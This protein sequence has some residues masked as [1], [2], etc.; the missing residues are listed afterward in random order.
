MSSPHYSHLWP[1]FAR[2]ASPIFLTVLCSFPTF[3]QIAKPPRVD[4]TNPF[5]D[6]AIQGEVRTRDDQP[7]PQDTIV[8]LEAVDGRPFAEQRIGAD[9]KFQFVNPPK[10]A[11]RLSVIATRYKTVT[12]TIDTTYGMPQPLVIKLDPIGSTAPP[13]QATVTD[14]AAPKQARREYEKGWQAFSLGKLKE[15]QRHLEKA[16]AE[17]PCFARA[18]TALGIVF[19]RVQQFEAADSA[20]RKS[21]KC[22]GGFFQGYMQ[23]ALLEW[24]Q[25]KYEA[26]SATL[27]QGL[28]QFPNQWTLHYDLARAK[29]S[30]GDFQTAEQ[31]YLKAQE[32]NPA[33]RPAIHLELAELYLNWKKYDKARAEMEAYL[34]ADP[35]GKSAQRTRKML[36]DLQASESA[37]GVPG[38]N[39]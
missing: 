33:T 14:L 4:P 35:N 26:C 16:V 22:D 5:P 2:T 39:D 30:L 6:L 19:T 18:Q 1:R 29:H 23:L 20:F 3:G 17:D 12:E 13:A 15:A 8:R 28:R 38:H 37:S 32:L 27:E 11:Y 31:E 36:Q 7:P 21:I 9:S 25:K 10:A 34:R 24:G